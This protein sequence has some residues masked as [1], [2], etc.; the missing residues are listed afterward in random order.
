MSRVEN[1]RSGVSLPVAV[2]WA[3]A[4]SPQS[5]LAWLCFLFP[6]IEPDRRIS[7]IRLSEKGSRVRPRK[8]AGPRSK[9]DKAQPLMQGGN[10]ELL[11]CL[12]SQLVLGAQPLA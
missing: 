11:G 7:R 5:G 4:P 10:W 3:F 6:L 8:A 2:D 1:R 9:L 12:P